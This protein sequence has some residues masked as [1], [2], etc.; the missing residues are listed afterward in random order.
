MSTSKKISPEEFKKFLDNVFVGNPDD[1]RSFC[2]S[3]ISPSYL[4]FMAGGDK[5]DFQRAVE[6]VA[7]F[8]EKCHT[9]KSSIVFFAQENNKIAA[10]LLCD[11]GIGDEPAKKMELMF[12]AELDEQGL[13]ESVWEQATEWVGQ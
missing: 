2:E 3:T 12:M 11:L 1:A 13:Y 7:Y 4:R 8:R 9:W 10:R 6:K 5:T